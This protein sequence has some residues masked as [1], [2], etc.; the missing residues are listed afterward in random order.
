[1][2]VTI[3]FTNYNL[4]LL[5]FDEETI[6]IYNQIR[7]VLKKRVTYRLLFRKLLGSRDFVPATIMRILLG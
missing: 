2:E 6:E 5:G 7:S 4:N 3:F 1:M